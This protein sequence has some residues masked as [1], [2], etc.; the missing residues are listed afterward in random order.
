VKNVLIVLSDEQRA[1]TLGCYGNTVAQ[2][3]HIDALAD[4]GMRFDNC[5]TPFPLCCPARA[6]LL[7]AMMPHNHH[8]VGNWRA[9]NP[10]LAEDGIV[11][12]F[13][14]AGYHMIYSG[15]W[16]VPG[17]DP[18]RMGFHDSSAIP[19]VING[20]D[21]GRYIE[22]YRSYVESKGYHL[23]PKHIENLTESDFEALQNEEKG[24][25]GTA[26]IPEEHFLETW[27][28]G[29]FLGNMRDRDRSKPF[30]AV[31][32]YSSPHFPMIVPKP[33]NSLIAP[34]DIELSEN[35]CAGLEGKPVEVRKLHESQAT[36]CLDEHAWRN[37]IA[38]Y[39]GLCSLVDT[40]VGKIIQ[41]LE[42]ED[43]LG[44]TIIVYSTDHGD[45]MG[46]HGLNRKGHQMHYQ[47]TN[48]IPM[49]VSHPDYPG[50]TN[51]KG[52]VSLV[53]LLPTLAAENG[54]TT[55][56]ELDGRSFAS[57]LQGSGTQTRDWVISESY[58]VKGDPGGNGEHFDPEQF[59]PDTDAI[60]MS[61]C[62]GMAKYIF[63][64]RDIDEYYDLV[65]DPGERVNLVDA[66]QITGEKK[67]IQKIL[68]DS[69][70]SGTPNLAATV[71]KIMCTEPN[72]EFSEV[73]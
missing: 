26:E 21:R 19:A 45:M 36:S 70:E 34:S 16:H 62:N 20:K 27:Q 40:Q 9:V 69:L 4:R 1:D 30:F 38:H 41:Y 39:Y 46:S 63:H 68:V 6:S 10:D 3:P 23:R 2:T 67:S 37:L 51:Q 61:A 42:E 35:F 11:R 57:L 14:S 73:P 12:D 48:R 7:T 32:S 28:T 31:V 15:K 29:Q 52:L 53:D 22:E 17:T 65:A 59:D 33:Y 72:L 49:I 8:V 18:H 47:E 24:P 25:Y 44:D 43:A 56:Q 55:Q 5:Y 66:P 60:N 50:G 71:Q 13:R 54:V 58:L 64:S